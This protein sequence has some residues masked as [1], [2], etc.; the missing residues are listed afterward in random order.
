MG[1][2]GRKSEACR[3]CSHFGPKLLRDLRIETMPECMMWFLAMIGCF[4]LLRSCLTGL[5]KMVVREIRQQD[6]TEGPKN[7][8]K[9]MYTILAKSEVAH[10]QNCSALR[11][12]KQAPQVRTHCGHCT[13]ME[14]R[15]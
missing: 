4:T 15:S 13:D 7:H 3:F 10:T 11:Q 12:S 2:D 6:A 9:L 1:F 5:T 14:R 8:E